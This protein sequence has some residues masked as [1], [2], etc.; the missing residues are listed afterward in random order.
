MG[1]IGY[2]IFFGIIFWIMHKG[3]GCC[4]GHRGSNSTQQNN[5]ENYNEENKKSNNQVIEMV[6]DPVCG[7]HIEKSNTISK[8]VN[9][10]IYYFCSKEC[11]NNFIE[12]S[13]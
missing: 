10:K 9:G 3:G 5:Q 1:A 11:A 4:G 6:Y 7:M 12:D 2:L 8:R 13:A